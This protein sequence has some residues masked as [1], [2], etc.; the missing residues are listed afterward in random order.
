MLCILTYVVKCKQLHTKYIKLFNAINNITSHIHLC[1]ACANTTKMLIAF[2][3]CSGATLPFPCR[4]ITYSLRSK[5]KNNYN[6]LNCNILFIIYFLMHSPTS[7]D[8]G[9]PKMYI[10]IYKYNFDWHTFTLKSL[11][12]CSNPLNSNPPL[13]DRHTVERSTNLAC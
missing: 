5:Y 12:I 9:A 10:Y 8:S 3:F 6:K 4:W 2:H 7:S 13:S 11:G 1:C